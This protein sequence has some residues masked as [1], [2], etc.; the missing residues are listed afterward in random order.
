MICS[1]NKKKLYQTMDTQKIS[2]QNIFPTR[3]LSFP[4]LKFLAPTNVLFTSHLLSLFSITVFRKECK[5]CGKNCYSSVITRVVH[6]TKLMLSPATKDLLL[7]RQKS[8]VIYEYKCHCDSWYV[9]STSQRLQ[10]RIN[11]HVPKWLIQHHT[12]SQ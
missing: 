10:D 2:S 7:A 11:H 4:N 9:G 5:N 6:V 8:F 12:S 1:K 3:S